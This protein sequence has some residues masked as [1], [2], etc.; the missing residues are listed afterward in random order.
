MSSQVFLTL[1]VLL[2]ALTSLLTEAVK[3]TLDGLKVNYINEVVV[4]IV[5]IVASIGGA[6]GYYILNDIDFS[7]KNIVIICALILCNYIGSTVG[8]DKIIELLEAIGL[9]NK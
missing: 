6:I 9:K 4:I 7:L 3:K 8:Y 5:D 1:F 2:S